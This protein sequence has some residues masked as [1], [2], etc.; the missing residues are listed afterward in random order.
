M[1]LQ[2]VFQDQ[3]Y[4]PASMLAHLVGCRSLQVVYAPAIPHNPRAHSICR[5]QQRQSRQF[6]EYVVL[7][8]FFKALLGLLPPRLRVFFFHRTRNREIIIFCLLTRR[9]DMS[10]V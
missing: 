1:N 10:E 4:P 8:I 5:R 7:G 3:Q 6:L 2:P 9:V